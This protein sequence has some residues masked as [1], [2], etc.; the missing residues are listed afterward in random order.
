MTPLERPLVCLVTDGAAGRGEAGGTTHDRLLE[1]GRQAVAAGV[2]LFQVREPGL[3]TALLV[4]LVTTLVNL[5]RET[6]TR[7]VVNDRLDVALACGA[8]GVHLRGDSIPPAA[9]RSIAPPH[10]LV[11]RSVHSVEEVGACATSVDYLIAGTVFP[12]ASKAGSA[13]F[14]GSMGLAEIARTSTRPVLGIGGVTL[15]KLPEIAAS[16][17]AGIAGIGLFVTTPAA[18]VMAAV[19]SAF[20]IAKDAS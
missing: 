1:L 14:I 10:F 2:H 3:D 12:T 13:R 18:D 5:A 11:G 20:D 15:E 7:V 8:A 9:A 6:S 19:R 4:R 17:A 16:G